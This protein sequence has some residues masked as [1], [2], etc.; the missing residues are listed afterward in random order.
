M[1]HYYYTSAE[2]L[3]SKKEELRQIG[4]QVNDCSE[5]L[6]DISKDIKELWVKNLQ[7]KK[8]IESLERKKSDLVLFLSRL[9]LRK[10]E[11]K[12]II[13]RTNVITVIVVGDR[14]NGELLN[15]LISLN[16]DILMRL[17][18]IIADENKIR[19]VFFFFFL[20]S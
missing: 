12:E 15:G 18:K 8:E 7:T 14:W 13:E 17:F 5:E 19:N 11:V 4:K 3:Q 20:I 16:R 1:V 6:K 10:E 2:E 9:D